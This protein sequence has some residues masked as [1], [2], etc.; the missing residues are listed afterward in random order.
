ARITAA[1]IPFT[2]DRSAAK[3]GR[4]IP[5]AAI[6]IRSP[7][8]LLD[9]PPDEILILTWD[10][11]DEVT[12]ALAPLAGRSRFVVP[13]PTLGPVGPAPEPDPA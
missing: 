7:D 10:I 3:L 13:L 5:G 11:A 1:D 9:T 6:P 2:V 4:F 8:V 12:R